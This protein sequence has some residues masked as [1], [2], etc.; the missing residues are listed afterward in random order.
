MNT[1]ITYEIIFYTHTH[2]Y[3]HTYIARYSKFAVCFSCIQGSLRL[4]PNY[5]YFD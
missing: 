4:I 1:W 5:N 3:T 2:T